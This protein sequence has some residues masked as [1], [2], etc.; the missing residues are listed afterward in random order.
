MIWISDLIKKTVYWNQ[1]GSNVIEP[2]LYLKHTAWYFQATYCAVFIIFASLCSPSNNR[3][4]VKQHLRENRLTQRCLGFNYTMH[5]Q[6]SVGFHNKLFKKKAINFEL[7]I[8]FHNY[9]K[10][11]A[12]SAVKERGSEACETTQVHFLLYCLLCFWG[13]A[14]TLWV[15]AGGRARSPSGTERNGSEP[16]QLDPPQATMPSSES[17]PVRE[18]ERREWMADEWR[19]RLFFFN[20]FRS[21]RDSEC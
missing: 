6:T 12:I 1:I 7:N 3:E 10:K 17:Q 2:Q 9:L 18:R 15:S 4:T 8:H 5:F 16:R 14:C 11:K 13:A 21:T 20:A 19:C